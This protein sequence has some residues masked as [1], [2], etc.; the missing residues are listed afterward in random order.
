MN[1]KDT[2]KQG[3]H[4]HKVLTHKVHINTKYSRWTEPPPKKRLSG[5]LHTFKK[6]KSA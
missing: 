5:H 1:D 4:V 2:G 3:F 6:S